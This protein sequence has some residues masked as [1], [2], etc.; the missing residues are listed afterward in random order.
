MDNR[1]GTV[2][3]LRVG[4]VV[5]QPW[6]PKGVPSAA[7]KTAVD[8][9]LRLGVLGFDGDEHGDTVNHGGQGKAAL[10][11][12]RHRY[13][14]WRGIGL[15]LPDGGFFE[16][17]TLDSPGTDDGTVV[18]GETWRIGNATVRVTQPRSPCYKLAKRWGIDD[19]VL[20]VQQTGWSGWYLAVVEEGD[21][22][23]GDP[24]TLLDRPAGAPTMAE[25]SRVMERD[26]DD[27]DG[28]RRLIDAPG[29]PARW[30]TKLERRLAG[31]P[32]SEAARLLGPAEPTAR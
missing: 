9:P 17:L 25:I 19:L 5:N 13:D 2:A 4:R 12:A 24:V 1:I 10:A 16:N 18:L 30:V 11:Y 27:L 23:P 7:V 21:V 6:G 15:D 20:R 3:A 26:K 31:R 28:A 29:L 22:G 14:D 32:D 8:G